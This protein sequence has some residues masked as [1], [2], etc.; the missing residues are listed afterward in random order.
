MKTHEQ[1]LAEQEAELR[2]GL[3]AKI[4][5]AGSGVSIIGSYPVWVIH[6]EAQEEDDSSAVSSPFQ[7]QFKRKGANITFTRGRVEA[8]SYAVIPT[9]SGLPV[10]DPLAALPFQAGGAQ[11]F[12]EYRWTLNPAPVAP[13]WA[14][15]FVSCELVQTALGAASP[16]DVLPTTGFNGGVSG[17][18]GIAHGFLMAYDASGQIITY[19]QAQILAPDPNNLFPADCVIFAFP[20]VSYVD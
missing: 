6:S 10:T 19:G 16:A 13:D 12:A 9:I 8:G 15:V 5:R 4:P 18:I 7:L 14:D 20:L 2:N 17:T 3:E 1:M 11:V